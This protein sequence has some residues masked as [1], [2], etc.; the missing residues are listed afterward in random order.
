MF[1]RNVI[2]KYLFNC[3]EFPIVTT[4]IGVCNASVY[5]TKSNE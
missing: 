2:D 3:V 4:F 1:D 5:R